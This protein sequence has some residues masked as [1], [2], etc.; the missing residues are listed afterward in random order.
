MPRGGARK[1][2]GPKAGLRK[3]AAKKELLSAA[4]ASGLMPSAMMLEGARELYE[5]AA[6]A[7]AEDNGKGKG[8][9][10]H[11]T[12]LQAFISAA[13][14]A[15]PYFEYK[16]ATMKVEQQPIDLT[17]LTDQQL[18]DLIAI[19]NSARATARIGNGASSA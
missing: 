14:Q 15:G 1:G 7:K 8:S 2:A 9:A 16:L 13:A 11:L 3:A 17:K 6:E 18:A 4:R 19:Y 12:L 5:M 10:K